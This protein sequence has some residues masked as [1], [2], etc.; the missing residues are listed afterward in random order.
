[1]IHHER[2]LTH[3]WCRFGELLIVRLLIRCSRLLV[4]VQHHFEVLDDLGTGLGLHLLYPL[5]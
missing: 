4:L 2:M 1:M 3:V 5:S